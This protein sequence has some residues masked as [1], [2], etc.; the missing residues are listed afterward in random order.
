VRVLQH[1]A[2]AVVLVYWWR[3]RR[4]QLA[5]INDGSTNNPG[6]GFSMPIFPPGTTEYSTGEVRRGVELQATKGLQPCSELR[7]PGSQTAG[8]S[9]NVTAALQV[10][11]DC[12]SFNLLNQ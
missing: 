7:Q 3:Q 9:C 12:P 4:Q 10:R 5:T 2:G 6:P 1:L 11:K 8:S